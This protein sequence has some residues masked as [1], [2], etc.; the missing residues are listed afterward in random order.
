M[1]LSVLLYKSSFTVKNALKGKPQ[2]V[3]KNAQQKLFSFA[4]DSGACE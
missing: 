1:L 2:K 4:A 3:T